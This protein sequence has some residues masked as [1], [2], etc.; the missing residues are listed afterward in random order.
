MSYHI[1][2]WFSQTLESHI[3]FIYSTVLSGWCWRRPKVAAIVLHN[4][5]WN[6]EDEWC[7]MTW[8]SSSEAPHSSSSRWLPV[9]HN[10]EFKKMHVGFPGCTQT[11]E[12]WKLRVQYSWGQEINLGYQESP[13][14]VIW[15]LIQ[16]Q[17]WLPAGEFHCINRSNKIISFKFK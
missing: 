7:F 13:A 14:K 8:K 15:K 17:N 4:T 12:V 3:L 5:R 11:R 16:H 9:F 6:W 10:S 2:V 1:W